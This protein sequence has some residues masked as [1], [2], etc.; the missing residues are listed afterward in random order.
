VEIPYTICFCC[1]QEQILMLYR[2][3][4]PH[5]QLWNGLGGKIE[6]GETPLASVQRE[7]REEAAIDLAKVPSLFFAGITSWGLVGQDPVKGMYV[8]IAHLS[9]QQ[10]EQV[11]TLN[12]PEGLIAWKPLAWVCDP[13]NQAVVNNIP[14]FLPPMLAAQIPYEYFDTYESEDVSAEASRQLIIRPLPSQIVL[15]ECQGW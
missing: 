12:T 8:F 1:Y 14:R 11:Q 3:F 2:T 7:M 15:S 6:A 10:A 9:P 13:G 5:A 4:P